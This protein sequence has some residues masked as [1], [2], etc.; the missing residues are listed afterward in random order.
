MDAEVPLTHHVDWLLLL[1]ETLPVDRG[2][3]ELL[4]LLPLH[5]CFLLSRLEIWI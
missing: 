5:A 4:L 1:E 2:E 3:Y